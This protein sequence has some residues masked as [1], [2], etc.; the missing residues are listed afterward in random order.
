[1]DTFFLKETGKHNLIVMKI[2]I[3][4]PAFLNKIIVKLHVT[5]VDIMNDDNFIFYGLSKICVAFF[6]ILLV[7]II[8]ISFS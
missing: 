2:F 4:F 6:Y 5:N 8:L 3:H 1:M 7:K